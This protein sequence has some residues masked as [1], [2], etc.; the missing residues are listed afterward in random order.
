M[1]K[2]GWTVEPLGCTHVAFTHEDLTG[3][4]HVV[5]HE[6]YIEIKI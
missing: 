5:E 4:V 3:G 2:L 6:S 1:T